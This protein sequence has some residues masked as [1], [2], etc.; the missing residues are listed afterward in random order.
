MLPLS[1]IAT[2]AFDASLRDLQRILGVRYAPFVPIY[3]GAPHN[4]V[5]IAYPRDLLRLED[6]TKIAGHAKSPWFIFEADPV[7]QILKQFR[8]NRQSIAIVLG[9]NG[10]AAGILTLDQIIDEIFPSDTHVISY[11]QKTHMECSL[12]GDMPIEEFNRRFNAALDAKKGKTL[13]DLICA[14]LNHLPTEG[15]AA[16]IDRF[17]LMVEEASLLGVKTV[18][19]RTIV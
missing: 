15:E 3:Q 9:K 13:S 19:V 12:P 6:S 8:H 16:Y 18:L 10:I 17:E 5:A 14:N 4:I 7:S 11:R 2:V 1:E